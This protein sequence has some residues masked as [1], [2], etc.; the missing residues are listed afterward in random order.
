MA[1]MLLGKIGAGS[2]VI[3]GYQRGVKGR[4]DA[5]DLNEHRLINIDLVSVVLASNVKIMFNI[6]FV[7]D[8]LSHSRASLCSCGTE[9]CSY[10]YSRWRGK[11]PIVEPHE[12]S[13]LRL[14]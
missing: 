4:E 13:P 6:L 14:P 3:V 10:S 8:R 1:V 12:R 7:I 5:I 9:S 2:L 11:G